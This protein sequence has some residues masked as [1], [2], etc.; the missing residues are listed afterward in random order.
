MNGWFSDEAKYNTVFTIS[1]Y[2]GPAC[3][4]IEPGTPIRQHTT[5]LLVNRINHPTKEMHELF[6]DGLFK[7]IRAL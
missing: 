3:Y 7:L 2:S 1:S 5:M 6:A 4:C